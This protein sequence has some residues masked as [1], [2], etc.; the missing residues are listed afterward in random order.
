[1]YKNTLNNIEVKLQ[2]LQQLL[3][4]KKDIESKNQD[5]VGLNEK[6]LKEKVQKVN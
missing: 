1:M 6:E 5:D 4:K 3:H 2:E